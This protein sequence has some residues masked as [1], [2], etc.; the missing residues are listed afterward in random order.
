M[1]AATQRGYDPVAMAWTQVH[2]HQATT[3]ENGPSNLEDEGLSQLVSLRRKASQRKMATKGGAPVAPLPLKLAAGN[4]GGL[5]SN[6]RAWAA[7]TR[8][9]T[10]TWRPR[11]TPKMRAEDIVVVLKPRETL[12]LKTVFQA[13]DL[14]AAIAQCVGGEAGAALNVWPHEEAANK[15]V[16]DFN[17]NV[18]S[19]SVPFRG[20]VKL[21]GE[22]C[23]GV[24][25]VWMDERTASL[26]G[27]VV[28]RKGELAFVRKLG[29][30][31]GAVLTFGGRRVPRYVHNKCECT[32]VRENKKTVPACGT[33]GHRIDNCPHPDGARCGFCGQRV[34]ASE[35]GLTERECTPS[36]MVCGKAHLT[37]FTDCKGKFRRLHRPGTQQ[38]GAPNNKTSKSS[39]NGGASSGKSRQATGPATGNRTSSSKKN[40]NR[41][42]STR[43]A[44]SVTRTKAP[45]DSAGDFPP[46]E[47]AHTKTRGE[48]QRLLRRALHGYQGTTAQL[49]DTLCDMY[50]C[51]IEDPIAPEYE[52]ASTV[53][54]LTNLTDSACLHLLEYINQI[55]DG[56]PLPP[57]WKT[58]GVT[59][60]PKP[61]KKVNTDNLRPIS[62]T[63]CA[64]KLVETMARDRLS[65]YME[66]KGLFADTTFGF[67]PHMSAQDGA[68]DNARHDSI[69]ANLS[70]TDCGHKAFAYVRDFLSKRQALLR[71][72]DDEYG[73][74]TMGTRGTPQGAVL[75]PLLFN[76]AMMQLPHLL[77]RVEGIQHSLYADDITIW[78]T[79][80]SLGDIEERL[81]RAIGCDLQCAPAKSKLLHVRANPKDNMSL[82]IS[83]TG[84]PIRKVEGIWILGLFIQN[85]L[86]PDST[87]AKLKRVG[88]QVGR[89][90]HCVSNKRGGLR[91]RYTLRLVHAFVTSR[92]LYYV[93]YLRTTKQHDERIDAIIREATKRLLNLPVATSIAKLMSLGVLTSCQELKEAHLV[94]QYT[95]LLQM[96]SGRHLL[97]RLHI[98]HECTPEEAC[99]LPELW[100]HKPWVSLLPRN[101]DT[102]TNEGRRKARAPALE[103]QYGSKHG[104]YY[105]DVAGPSL[106]GFYTAAVFHQDQRVNGLSYRAINS[107]QA[108][109]V[110][111]ALAASAPHSKVIITDSRR[112]CEHDLAGEVSPLA[113]RILSKPRHIRTP[114]LNASFGLLATR[115]FEVT[116]EAADA[117]ARALTHR[118]P[119]PGSSGSEIRQQLLRFKEILA[120]YC[121]RHR[122]F[123]VP[124]KGLSGAD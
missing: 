118:A 36:C 87:I 104:V 62:L 79:E 11:D 119:H 115:A 33:I 45:T 61:R 15:L 30:S 54:L 74:Y 78:T 96:V 53:K 123:P 52:Y 13:G 77:A 37:G 92:I 10:T 47:R 94:N 65:S 50:L 1:A 122:L 80:G 38:H 28:W 12:H 55:W 43:S 82:R 8:S 120:D 111:I 35:Q 117:A 98:Q 101:M 59:F 112:A 39:G 72:E 63:S 107:A 85:L 19:G 86:S 48:T 68:F 83:L 6:G 27:K 17:I 114:H 109:E 21:N 64:G 40:K 84:G 71:I 20:H 24:I 3:T 110:A 7:Q 46:L 108:E 99:R 14:G 81:Q 32:V 97:D 29:T 75:S 113:H 124:A 105:V 103:H 4:P 100:R 58:S 121:E 56:R 2:V 106:A 18:G 9:K 60:I 90:I 73:R 116:I 88:E 66:A 67:S 5:V 16:R 42:T 25:T 102:Q 31:N 76:I 91:G 23:R 41:K 89:M 34:G 49:A 26:K 57:D 93:P 70:T 69:L 51:R 95:R 44:K 22:V